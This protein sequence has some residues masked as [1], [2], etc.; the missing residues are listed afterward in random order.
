MIDTIK[1]ILR[2]PAVRAMLVVLLTVVVT[3]IAVRLVKS[4][5]RS[6][7]EDADLR[8]RASKIPSVVGYFVVLVVLGT[9]VADKFSGFTVALGAAS[10]GIAFALQ[11]V[12]ASFAG[13]LAVA[14]GNFFKVGDRV[15]LGGIKGDVIDIGFLRTTIMEVGSWVNGDLYNGRIVRVANSFVFKEPVFNYSGEFGFLWDEIVVP[16][17]YGSD[18]ELARKIL[19]DAAQQVVGDTEAQAQADWDKLVRSYRIEDARVESLVTLVAN[20]NW[21][22]FTL[23]YVVKHRARR[24]T[25]DALF[26]RILAAV[27]KSEGKVAMASM[28]VHI[29]ET[30]QLRVLLNK[31]K[32]LGAS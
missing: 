16:V 29:V 1:V 12:I 17:K 19:K 10:A 22:E 27:D 15:Q 28:T 20:D 31:A 8:Y 23:R 26:S 18:Y 5:I 4:G 30:P 2:I 24:A 21:V 13:W 25:K 32:E 14:F 11:E 3:A 9:Q 7:V 6:R